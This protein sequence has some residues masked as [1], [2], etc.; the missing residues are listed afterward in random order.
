[1]LSPSYTGRV[2]EGFEQ[3]AVRVGEGFAATDLGDQRRIVLD[4]VHAAARGMAQFRGLELADFEHA[5]AAVVESDYVFSWTSDWKSSPGRR[6]RA[7]CFF[8]ARQSEGF[9]RD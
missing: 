3:A 1:V 4:A 8:R 7:R 6:W 5:R 9:S 2:S